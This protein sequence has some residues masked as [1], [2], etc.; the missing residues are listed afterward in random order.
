VD[1]SEHRL[2]DIMDQLP[3]GV[4][5]LDRQARIRYVN[6]SAERHLAV[7]RSEASGRV[8]WDVIANPVGPALRAVFD[9]VLAG[10]ELL[11]VPSVFAQGRWLEVVARP[12]GDEVVVFG[13]DITER[14]QAETLR[15]QTEERF[16]ILIDGVKDYAILLL[17]PKG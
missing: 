13:R 14:L 8:A 3:D 15:K 2:S 5:V 16:R 10:E 11:V 6:V 4:A 9:R 12:L 1:I 7:P 17:D